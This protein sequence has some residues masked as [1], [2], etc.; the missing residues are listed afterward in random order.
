MALE[1][2]TAAAA[3]A[4][5]QAPKQIQASQSSSSAVMYTVPSGREFTGIVGTSSYQY[6]VTINGEG[7]QNWATS[8][9][10]FPVQMTFVA[11]TVIKGSP[12]A[13]SYIFGV[14]RDAT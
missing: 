5:A 9:S 11:G 8:Y 10:T 6:F 7:N 4:T 13:G 3:T 1:V 12:N 14:E 2:Q